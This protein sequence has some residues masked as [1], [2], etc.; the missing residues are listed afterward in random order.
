M[1]K[2]KILSLVIFT[3]YLLLLLPV[4]LHANETKPSLAWFSQMKELRSRYPEK[5]K[6]ETEEEYLEKI[7]SIKLSSSP[8]NLELTSSMGIYDVNKQTLEIF[9]DKG[10]MG[11]IPEQDKKIGSKNVF[12]STN[13]VINYRT[14]LLS[15][16]REIVTCSNELGARSTY[17]HVISSS[18]QYFI[19]LGRDIKSDPSNIKSY[20]ITVAMTPFQALK[21]HDANENFVKERIKIYLTL[22]PVAP[23]YSYDTIDSANPC[24]NK[25]GITDHD[26]RM[27]LWDKLYNTSH[28]STTIHRKTHLIH[29][30]VA[31]IKIIDDFTKEIIYEKSYDNE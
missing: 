2:T 8:I 18:V 7:N 30:Q 5:S 15:E 28:I 21:Y 13:D 25:T 22:Q 26:D 9:L 23:F 16:E 1:L 27:D 20:D 4:P 3:N 11:G 10:Y 12:S 31:N 19:N 6:F 14:D 29:T 17:E 24:K